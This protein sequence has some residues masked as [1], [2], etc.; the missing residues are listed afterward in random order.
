MF[1]PKFTLPIAMSALLAASPLVHAQSTTITTSSTTTAGLVS[2]LR[3]DALVIRPSN[4]S[5]PIQYSSSAT[6]TFVDETG[7]PVSRE[8]VTSGLPVTVEYFRDGERLIANRVVIRRQTTT[9][10]AAPTVIEKTTTITPPPVVVE[11]PV[12]VEKKV[13]VDRPV[14]VEK[15]VPV[16]V[17]KKVYVDRPVIVEKPAPAPV[18]EEKRTTT[19]TTTTAGSKKEK[20]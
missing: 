6:T 5:T 14:I 20:D 3:P 15:K 13:Y 19:T 1:T 10:S 18:I 12:A 8:L 4:S 11:K 17:E 9:T 2:E 7:A 16:A